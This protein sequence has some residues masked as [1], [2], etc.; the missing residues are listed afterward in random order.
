MWF[1][2][3]CNNILIHWK[4]VAFPNTAASSLTSMRRFASVPD[5]NAPVI[6][7]AGKHVVIDRAD[8]Q[9]VHSI[10]M[11]EHVQS[12]PPEG[13]TIIQMLMIWVNEGIYGGY[14]NGQP[15]KDFYRGRGTVS[16]HP[17]LHV[18]KNH[19]LVISYKTAN[20][21]DLTWRRRSKTSSH[22]HF[23]FTAP[24]LLRQCL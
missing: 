1:V 15:E 21:K 13:A 12:F 16:L 5:E 19:L 3:F 24:H 8:R 14:K 18:M 17:P 9:A 6:R 4:P 23:L 7:R 11:Q 10:D 22:V 20:R 2:H